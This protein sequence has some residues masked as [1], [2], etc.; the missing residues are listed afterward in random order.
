MSDWESRKSKQE[1]DRR[2]RNAYVQGRMK[3]RYDNLSVVQY[4]SDWY[5]PRPKLRKDAGA[6]DFI[7]SDAKKPEDPHGQA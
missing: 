1:S 2:A 3:N 4:G 6:L 7:F 5:P